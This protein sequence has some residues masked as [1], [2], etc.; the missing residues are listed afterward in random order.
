[1]RLTTSIPFVCTLALFTLLFLLQMYHL[2]YSS[3]PSSSKGA[4]AYDIKDSGQMRQLHPFS[5][6]L[7]SL[8]FSF[9]V[10]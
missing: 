2:S 9:L 4:A 7:S 8:S 3:S 5:L 10:Y 1:M 6:S